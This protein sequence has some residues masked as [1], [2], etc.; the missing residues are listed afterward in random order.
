MPPDTQIRVSGTG[1]DQKDI[2]HQMLIDRREDE[3]I[4]V[5]YQRTVSINRVIRSL[6]QGYLT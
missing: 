2:L 1:L 5:S 3:D 4:K 6:A